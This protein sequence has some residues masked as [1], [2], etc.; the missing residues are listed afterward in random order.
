[1]FPSAADPS[2]K[3]IDSLC[4]C[5]DTLLEAII[6]TIF[7]A[8]V[9][10]CFL[11]AYLKGKQIISKEENVGLIINNLITGNSNKLHSLNLKI[12]MYRESANCYGRCAY[13]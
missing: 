1:M 10:F 4:T 9:V 2:D 8:V 5:Q 6:C 13:L 11:E 12:L 3:V 7:Q